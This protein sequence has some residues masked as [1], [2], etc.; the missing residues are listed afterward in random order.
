MFR[1]AHSGSQK[2]LGLGQYGITRDEAD[3][4]ALESQRRAEAAITAGRFAPEITAAPGTDAKGKP[5]DL[6]TDEHPRFGATIEGLRKL[7]L[8]FGPVDGQTG[9]ITAGNASGITDGGAAV[10]VASGDEA[11]EELRVMEDAP[12][13]PTVKPARRR[14]RGRR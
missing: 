2:A 7:P 8:A 6:T 9:I 14:A 4:F 11:R 10:V 3:A 1:L 5:V 13:L 12:A